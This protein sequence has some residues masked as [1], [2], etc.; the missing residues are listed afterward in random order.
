MKIIKYLFIT[1][2]L[3]IGINVYAEGPKEDGYI[4]FM[5]DPDSDDIYIY[6]QNGSTITPDG[7]SYDEST[8]TL[9][10]NNFN[11]DVPEQGGQYGDIKIDN[12]GDITIKFVGDNIISFNKT[13]QSGFIVLDR[14]TNVNLEGPG[15]LKFT[16]NRYFI[17]GTNG[18][19]VNT[20]NFNVDATFID[21]LRALFDIAGGT[22]NINDSNIT[23]RG[24][25]DIE[26]SGA[27]VNV[28]NSTIN[29]I[30][31]ECQ[32]TNLD[33]IIGS[34]IN[35]RFCGLDAK[36]IKNSTLNLTGRPLG[37]GKYPQYEKTIEGST[38]NIKYGTYGL[39][40]EGDPS[41]T[42]KLIIDNSNVNIS[43][44]TGSEYDEFA[45][46]YE[47]DVRDNVLG[48]PVSL[49]SLFS[50]LEITGTEIVTGGS[51]YSSC[52]GALLFGQDV[53]VYYIAEEEIDGLIDTIIKAFTGQTFADEDNARIAKISKNIVIGTPEK[54]EEQQTDVIPNVPNTGISTIIS[55]VLGVQILIAGAYIL[56][57]NSKKETIN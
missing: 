25:F 49:F 29:A 44:L 8:N 13:F 38:I 5:T 50:E 46:I 2:I 28:T 41:D 51:L 9:T 43:P 56:I 22:V 15:N 16:T 48:A 17:S 42:A 24:M 57:K 32:L 33:E 27:F 35:V 52:G 12:M 53:C 3:F 11:L 37:I 36:H 40:V 21:E 10:F 7:L 18:A 23:L 1:L 55:V 47:D 14:N 45:Q 30:G 39:I 6:R 54:Q 31:G 20:N 4:S 19:N 34:T 26:M